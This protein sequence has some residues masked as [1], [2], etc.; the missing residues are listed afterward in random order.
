MTT[1]F[2]NVI[3]FF[4]TKQ[5][6]YIMWQYCWS[7]TY[8]SS[9][10]IRLQKLQS[11]FYDFF[12]YFSRKSIRR[13]DQEASQVSHGTQTLLSHH[14]NVKYTNYQCSTAS[15]PSDNLRLDARR[16]LRLILSG[17]AWATRRANR[18]RSPRKLRPPSKM[19]RQC[20]SNVCSCSYGSCV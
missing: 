5:T 6:Y 14:M 1:V 4:Y 8:H 7:A 20:V 13:Q 2:L 10:S 12:I 18:P 17:K 3:F 9:T 11:L 19:P 15:Q 16:R